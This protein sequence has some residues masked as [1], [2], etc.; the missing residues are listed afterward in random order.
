MTVD[1][2]ERR[3]DASYQNSTYQKKTRGI[4]V[5]HTSYSILRCYEPQYFLS[6]TYRV[7]SNYP[8]DV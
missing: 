2:V 3:F 4:A 5:F 8:L 7:D 6:S 1:G